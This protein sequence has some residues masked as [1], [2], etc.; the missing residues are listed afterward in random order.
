VKERKKERR[1]E[2]KKEKRKKERK[3]EKERKRKKEKSGVAK[4]IISLRYQTHINVK[5]EGHHNCSVKHL[6]RN[7]HPNNIYT[8]C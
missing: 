6:K 1:K 3:K 5:D 7:T 4:C 8:F 2:R